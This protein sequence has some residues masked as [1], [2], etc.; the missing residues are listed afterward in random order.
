MLEAFKN[1]KLI[2][3][4]YAF[5]IILA[6]KRYFDEQ[7]TVV[8]IVLPPEGHISVCGDTHGQVQVAS[9]LHY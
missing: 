2:H 1:Q 8:D 5:Q 4:K 7:P 9:F 3:K 6:A